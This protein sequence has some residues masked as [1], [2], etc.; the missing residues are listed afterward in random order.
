MPAVERGESIHCCKAKERKFLSPTGAFFFFFFHIPRGKRGFPCSHSIWR[1]FTMLNT[2]EQI[3]DAMSSNPEGSRLPEKKGRSHDCGG[4]SL[5]LWWTL[6]Q[7]NL[8]YGLQ[9]FSNVL[10]QRNMING[11]CANKCWLV[12]CRFVNCNANHISYTH[13]VL[14]VPISCLCK[15]ELSEVIT[16]CLNVMWSSLPNRKFYFLYSNI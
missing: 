7:Q 12:H 4:T 9:I 2:P 13:L 1:T 15:A 3:N 6:I 14:I 5:T 11:V 10:P 8:G 16:P